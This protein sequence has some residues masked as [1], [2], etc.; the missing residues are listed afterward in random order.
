MTNEKGIHVYVTA[1]SAFHKF[2]NP[3]VDDCFDMAKSLVTALTYGMQSR[4]ASH[5]RIT[6]LPALLGKL[7]SGSEIGPAT[8]IGED[9]RVLE[10]NRV[11]KLRPDPSYPG[12][13]YMKLLKKEVGELALHVL[14]RG[15]AD[16]QSLAYVPSAPISNY[17]GPEDNRTSL[18]AH[19]NSGQGIA[20]R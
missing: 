17:V 13:Y 3:M 10:V 2:V 20:V 4:C 5:G 7:I 16:A 15:D 19:L 18:L 11:V 1:P 14:T 6:V 8:A 9:Y 12:R